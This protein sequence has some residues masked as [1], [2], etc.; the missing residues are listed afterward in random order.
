MSKVL[1]GLLL[2]AFLGAIDGACAGFYDS[3]PK[4]QLLGIVIGSTFKG[5]LTGVAAGM[6]ARKSRS[7]GKGITLG[8][9][10]GLA[11]SYVVAALPTPDG[12]HYYAEIMLPGMAL[13]AVVG[14]ATQRYGFSSRAGG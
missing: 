11:L 8:L 3:V 1:L 6:Y 12:L 14:F 10:V 7:L 2:G 4:D 9:V 5:L 13:G